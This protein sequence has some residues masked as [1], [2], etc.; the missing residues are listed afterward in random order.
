[1][2]KIK[3]PLI[4]NK[5]LVVNEEYKKV[6]TSAEEGSYEYYDFSK[7]KVQEIAIKNINNLTYYDACVL[8]QAL[9][10]K[11]LICSGLLDSFLMFEIKNNERKDPPKYCYY[12]LVNYLNNDKESKVNLLISEIIDL[13]KANNIQYH[14]TWDKALKEVEEV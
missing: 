3:K 5:E 7:E 4:L 6:I 2:E 8:V 1:M 11:Y 10:P 12:N 14:E 9:F 13:F